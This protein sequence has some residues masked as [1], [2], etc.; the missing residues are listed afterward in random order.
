MA[1]RPTIARGLALSSKNLILNLLF[2]LAIVTAISMPRGQYFY[3]MWILKGFL[4]EKNLRA[5][6]ILDVFLSVRPD[7]IAKDWQI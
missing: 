7:R 5:A 1:F 3:K 2:A 4:R 6:K